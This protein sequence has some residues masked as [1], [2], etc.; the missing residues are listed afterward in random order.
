MSGG[1]VFKKQRLI[2]QEKPPSVVRFL[3]QSS[4]LTVVAGARHVLDQQRPRPAG[5]LVPGVGGHESPVVE[6]FRR[7]IMRPAEGAATGASATVCERVL[8]RRVNS[9]QRAAGV[10]PP[11]VQQSGASAGRTGQVDGQVPPAVVGQ[12]EPGLDVLQR[13]HVTVG[14]EAGVDAPVD[15]QVA[16][17]VPA[18]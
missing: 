13:G 14:A 12:G 16:A 6:A 3:S 8:R 17:D 7:V 11:G 1:E 9:T 15:Q 18:E 5:V 4:R 10:L 2:I